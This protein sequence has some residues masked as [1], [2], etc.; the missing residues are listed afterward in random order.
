MLRV[1]VFGGL[2]VTIDGKEVL[3]GG[4]QRR[5][6]TSL[7][8]S[9]APEPVRVVQLVDCLDP[10][11]SSANPLNALQ[12]HIRRLR[13]I[14]EPGVTARSA[15]RLI[16]SSGGYALVPDEMDLWEF[17]RVLGEADA[18][19]NADPSEAVR[20]YENALA[21]WSDPW[22]D[23]GD[24]PLLVAE[25]A[26][27][28]SQMLCAEDHWAGAVVSIG[29]STA[30]T[31]HLLA[32]ARRE[33]TREQRWASAMHAL[34]QV[35]RQADS[36]RLHEEIRRYLRD[37]L[38]LDPSEHLSRMHR[39]VLDQ[40]PTL[41]SRPTEV[42]GATPHYTTTYVGRSH[43]LRRLSKLTEHS[44]LV[45]ITG[46]PGSG[47]TRLAHHW[48]IEQCPTPHAIWVNLR[49]SSDCEH[50]DV[51]LRRA[52]GI[53]NAGD[54]SPE[55][56]TPLLALPH[57]PMI[58]VLDG[59][60]S[61]P[62]DA[63]RLALGLLE[64]RPRLR[65]LVTGHSA[66]GLPG[67]ELLFLE[68]LAIPESGAAIDGTAV[69]LAQI[70][71]G[72]DES[73]HDAA[74]LA[75]RCAG[76]PLAIEVEAARLQRFG[77]AAAHEIDICE[78]EL[79][80][81]TV[82]DR[83]VAFLSPAARRLLRMLCVLPGG[84]SLDVIT[85][86][87]D[88]GRTEGVH[89]PHENRRLIAELVNS[90]LVGAVPTHHS[91]RYRVRDQVT[92]L[93][94]AAMTS[95]E[96]SAA[97]SAMCAWMSE[98]LGASGHDPG[99]QLGRCRRKL[100]LEEV[101]NI[102]HVLA[103]LELHDASGYLD[104]VIAL[105]PA[106]A[107]TSWRSKAVEWVD[108]ALRI[109]TVDQNR[110]AL[111]TIASVMLEADLAS[112]AGRRAEI[113]AA[114][115]LIASCDLRRTAWWF[116]A[117]MQLAI[118]AGWNGELDSARGHLT[119][120]ERA[121]GDTPWE[122]AVVDRYRSLVVFAGGAVDEALRLAIDSADRLESLG[123]FPQA[124]G[125]LYFAITIARSSNTDEYGNLMERARLLATSDD[126]IHEPLILSEVARH[127]QKTSDPM[128]ALI[129]Q[130]AITQLEAAG[131]L[132][133]AATTRRDL[134][135]FHLAQ[136]AR[137]DARRQLLHSAGTLLALD[138]M[139]ASLAL[140]GLADCERLSH[141]QIFEDLS[142]AAWEL[143]RSHG[144]PLSPDQVSLLTELTDPTP[145]QPGSATTT[146]LQALPDR[147]APDDGEVESG[148]VIERARNLLSSI[149]SR[150]VQITTGHVA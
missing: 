58:V 45:T 67:E 31:E 100:L 105:V 60:E 84:M 64:A 38:G 128:T 13:S 110:R 36:L 127:A 40:D 111:A 135:L 139:G 133:T 118:T 103:S 120:A 11:A 27:L 14:V 109:P 43:E 26:R 41:L 136:G 56:A 97:N 52:L 5:R 15:T 46:L 2:H 98:V 24:D 95:A 106:L 142:T 47:K 114:H 131:L 16:S 119:E 124:V 146:R 21:M 17:Q 63:C 90:T 140:G 144:T 116:V 75:R 4:N 8:A 148:A 147:N 48:L 37:E 59:I 65:L 94:G 130:K 12:A 1:T 89:D 123:D 35:G 70:R 54:Q 117:N 32:M 49:R 3:L 115:G 19:R 51:A 138:P 91:V 9:H 69:Q 101:D 80:L 129:S 77:A 30:Q 104:L 93:T 42:R 20:Q 22:G 74:R 10:D 53:G 66:I 102:E 121:G 99:P 7:L 50:A 18:L 86:L 29:A 143:R 61:H 85:W 88:N 73:I 25:T 108:K 68:P 150:E 71:L 126:S 149:T 33:P 134:G 6:V 92:T 28:R 141:E 112:V 107:D 96:T 72:P 78:G 76:L 113:E 132:R 23:L 83:A 122:N 39:R 145:E 137:L 34:Y 87:C 82:V 125:A 81:E 44:R 79:D 55:G 57:D 62:A